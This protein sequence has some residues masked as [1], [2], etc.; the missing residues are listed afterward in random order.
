MAE[1]TPVPARAMR[2]PGE[3]HP[4]GAQLTERRLEAVAEEPISPSISTAPADLVEDLEV[5]GAPAAPAAAPAPS[6][7]PAPV[8][9]TGSCSPS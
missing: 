8:G 6:P 9:A 2:R 7:T 5:I 4:L 3:A 1:R